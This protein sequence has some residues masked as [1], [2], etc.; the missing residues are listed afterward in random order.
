MDLTAA[1]TT[2]IT[3]HITTVAAALRDGRVQSALVVASDVTTSA[4]RS[5]DEARIQAAQK[6]YA[7]VRYAAWDVTFNRPYRPFTYA[8]PMTA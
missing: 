1:T 7:A 4:Y 6:F 3:P 5:N 2:Y 8:A